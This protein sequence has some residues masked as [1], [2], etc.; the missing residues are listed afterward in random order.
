MP[1]D[2]SIGESAYSYVQVIKPVIA[3][4]RNKFKNLNFIDH[5]ELIISIDSNIRSIEIDRSTAI[6]LLGS[7]ISRCFENL[8]WL[9]N[10]DEKLNDG[11]YEQLLQITGIV[12]T[13]NY[14]LQDIEIIKNLRIDTKDYA[15]NSITSKL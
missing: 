5:N 14:E 15:I 11:L 4:V 7:K 6:H 13:I 9:K 3:R 12:N 2:Q 10:L 8:L 1:L